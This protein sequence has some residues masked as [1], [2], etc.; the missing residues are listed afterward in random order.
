MVLLN[1]LSRGVKRKSVRGDSVSHFASL[2][3]ARKP[4]VVRSGLYGVQPWTPITQH[5]YARLFRFVQ[6]EKTSRTHQIRKTQGTT[7]LRFSNDRA[8]DQKL[9][10]DSRV[11]FASK[12]EKLT[13]TSIRPKR[14]V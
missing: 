9:L 13:S 11:G 8:L 12:C 3:L 6:I 10:A 14:I 1:Y 2:R 5:E 4:L 7:T